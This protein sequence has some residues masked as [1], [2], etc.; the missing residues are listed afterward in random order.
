MPVRE[1]VLG[2]PVHMTNLADAA[3]LAESWIRAGRRTYTCHVDA[4]LV[5]AS[6]SNPVLHAVLEGAD[7]CCTD[8]MP[9]VWLGRL[10]GHSVGRVYGPDFMH[11]VLARTA[12]WTDRSCR[13]FLF[14]ATPEILAE[15]KTR[16][17]ADHP[18]NDVVGM[19]AP[20]MGQW[21]AQT[22]QEYRD[23]IEK[24]A[25]DVLWVSLGAPRQELWV[26]ENR[27]LLTVPLVVPVGAAF[28]FL[29]GDKPQ[30]PLW[31]RQAGFEWL[32]RLL[33]EPQRLVKRYLATVPRFLVLAITEEL[34][35]RARGM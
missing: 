34:V 6:R 13:H 14:G 28:S 17:L 20:P 5:L 32:F 7:L 3:A 35:R 2:L 11:A 24:A 9:L 23:A 15:L 21:S 10:R 4:R 33:T 8:G 30:A 18:G 1:T 19:L 31:L 12:Q 27:Q 29:S 22:A 25:P 16:L 26:A